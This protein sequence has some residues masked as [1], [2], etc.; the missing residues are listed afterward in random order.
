MP[1]R[2][3]IA[4]WIAATNGFHLKDEA[5]EIARLGDGGWL[6]IQA[7]RYHHCEPRLDNARRYK[8]VEIGSKGVLEGPVEHAS[9]LEAYNFEKGTNRFYGNVPIDVAE[10]YVAARGGILRETG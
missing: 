10:R 2:L 6:S 1:H 8:A 7:S 4:E 5:R 9:L 3:T